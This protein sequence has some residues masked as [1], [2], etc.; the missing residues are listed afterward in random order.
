MKVLKVKSFTSSPKSPSPSPEAST[1]FA[2][3]KPSES[4]KKLNNPIAIFLRETA[5]PLSSSHFARMVVD[6]REKASGGDATVDKHPLELL[7]RQLVLDGF[8]SARSLTLPN[9]LRVVVLVVVVLIAVIFFFFGA[10]TSS[11]DEC[12]ARVVVVIVVSI[13]SYIVVLF[14]TST[15][16]SF[17]LGFHSGK[18]KTPCFP[19]LKSSSPHALTS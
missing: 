2:S 17:D 15:P 11:G 14:V 4:D 7:E 10:A 1:D 16:F 6:A 13:I 12:A 8:I 19:D 9:S 18:N 5:R 3:K